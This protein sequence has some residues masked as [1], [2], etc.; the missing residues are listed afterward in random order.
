[1]AENKQ[2]IGTEDMPQPEVLAYETT[3]QVTNVFV[4][5]LKIILKDVAYA[6]AK[7]YFDFLSHYNYVLPIAILN[8]FLKRLSDLPY[9]YVSKLF[10][11]IQNKDLFPKYFID[12]T[13]KQNQTPTAPVEKSKQAKSTNK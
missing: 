4:N 3:F 1:M 9:K 7:Q 2:I 13:P 11:I 8:E 6:D 10:D 12:I 5:D